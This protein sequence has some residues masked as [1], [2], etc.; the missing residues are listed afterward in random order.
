MTI[1]M[2]NQN[3][4]LKWHSDKYE[5][6]KGGKEKFCGGSSICIDEDFCNDKK[7]YYFRK[8]K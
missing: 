7:K 8:S 4:Y 1:N 3:E 6:E 5:N 2:T